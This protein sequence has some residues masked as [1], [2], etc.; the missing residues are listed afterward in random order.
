R[1]ARAGTFARLDV[2]LDLTRDWTYHAWK[3]GLPL[4]LIVLMAYG[5]YF[6]P[7]T[8]VNQQIGL[9]MTS[10]LTMIAYMLALGGTP[11]RISY[12]TRAVRFS[13]GSAVLVSL[14]LVR[15]LLPL[16]LAQRPDTSL[17]QRADRWGRRLYPLAMLANFVL[18]FFY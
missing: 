4:V 7:A 6:I 15:A 17:I 3:L 10:M 16:A 9:G 2:E 5:V 8:S 18:A 13:V 1:I 12:L 11:P 14:G